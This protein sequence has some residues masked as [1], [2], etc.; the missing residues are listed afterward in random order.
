M[1]K[2][3]LILILSLMLLYL[4]FFYFSYSM[5]KQREVYISDLNQTIVNIHQ[6]IAID[7]NDIYPSSY[8]L[9]G[10]NKSKLLENREKKELK[11]SNKKVETVKENKSKEYNV[12]VKYRTICV[13]K[14]CWELVGIMTI[15]GIQT[16]TLLSKEKKRKLELFKIGDELLPNI[17]IEKIK[18]ESMILLNK[19]KNKEIILKLFD[20]DLSKY[21]PK[22]EKEKNE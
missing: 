16:L 1:K 7:S 19:E 9:W 2:Y 14:H 15:D 18:G 12:D 13:E 10:L 8:L 4:V 5:P 17:I 11:E 21:L 3:Q 20:V 6:R 22:N